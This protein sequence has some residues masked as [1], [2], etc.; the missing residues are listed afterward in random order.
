MRV[1]ILGTGTDVGKTYVTACLGRTLRGHGLESVLA[2]KPIESGVAPGDLGDAGI[3]ATAAGHE[4]VLSSWRFRAAVSPHLAAREQNVVLDCAE[5]GTWVRSQEAKRKPD[6]SL[7]ELAGG[8]FSP[9]GVGVANVDLALALEPSV[10]LL[11][12]PDSLGAL[13]D[14]TATLRAMPRAPDAV[15]LSACRTPDQSSGT[16]AAELA[17]LGVVDVLEVVAADANACEVAAD[18]LLRHQPYKSTQKC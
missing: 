16:N 5:I 2:L 18:W 10:W 8:A 13:H 11:V 17:R 14:L 4:A 3:I 6:V 15:L 1:V 9:L 7:V 12:A